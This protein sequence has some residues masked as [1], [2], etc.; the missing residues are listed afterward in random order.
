MKSLSISWGDRSPT[1]TGSRRTSSRHV[2]AKTGR[3]RITIR[4]T[5]RAGNTTTVIR[6]VR[7]V[8]KPRP[9]HRKHRKPGKNGAAH[10]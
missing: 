5:D 6:R 8:P 10:A 9:K 1:L 3:Y 2:Y 7:I 4:L